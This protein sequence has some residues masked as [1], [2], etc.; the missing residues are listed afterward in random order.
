MRLKKTKQLHPVFLALQSKQPLVLEVMGLVN[1][2]K[3]NYTLQALQDHV[4][5][6]IN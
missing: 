3:L 1:L 6:V 4:L 5:P 2:Y